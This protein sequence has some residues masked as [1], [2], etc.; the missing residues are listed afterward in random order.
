[1]HDPKVL[2]SHGGLWVNRAV[3]V[4]KKE[5][6]SSVIDCWGGRC[7]WCKYLISQRRDLQEGR[8]N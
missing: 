1:M 6:E 2:C 8:K 7:R 4:V 3:I 5:P